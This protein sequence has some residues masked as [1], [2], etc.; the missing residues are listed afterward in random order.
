MVGLFYGDEQIAGIDGGTYLVAVM[1]A[2]GVVATAF[3]GLAI[4]MVIRRE[5]GVLKRVRGTPMPPALYVAGVIGSWLVV[6]ALEVLGQTLEDV[7]L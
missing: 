2:Y 3:A 6:I 4:T 1:I 5:S 7:Y